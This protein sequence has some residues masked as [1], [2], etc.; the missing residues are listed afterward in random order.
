MCVPAPSP[1]PVSW[2][3]ATLPAATSS[4]RRNCMRRMIIA[5][6]AL[7]LSCSLAGH[8]LAQGTLKIGMT[9]SDIPY[10]GGQTDNGFEG[11]RFVGYQVYE[12]LIA[13]DLTRGGPLAPP[14]PRAPQ[15][16]GV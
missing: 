12:S 8:A 6:L 15:A 2:P 11:F 7:A 4:P 5:L 1:C 16:W 14:G 9:A 13:W 10:T 3:P